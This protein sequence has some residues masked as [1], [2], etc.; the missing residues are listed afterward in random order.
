MNIPNHE[1]REHT[2]ILRLRI[3]LGFLNGDFEEDSPTSCSWL[4]GLVYGGIMD[5]SISLLRL[6]N[7]KH[8]YL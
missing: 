2:G 5:L 7:Q 4:T 3:C 1:T 6:Y 8:P